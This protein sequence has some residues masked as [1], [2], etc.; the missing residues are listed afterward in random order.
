[1]VR[2]A[3]N[4]LDGV[5]ILRDC[6][7]ADNKELGALLRKARDAYSDLEPYPSTRPALVI[8]APSRCHETWLLADQDATRA[9]LGSE[10]VHR[11]SGNPED[12]P[13]CDNLK[14]HLENNARRLHESLTEVRR[15]LSFRARPTELAKRCQY[16]YPPFV[17]DV[18]QELRD[19]FPHLEVADETQPK[20]KP[21]R[22]RKNP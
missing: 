19:L 14:K 5:V 18:Q 22:L 13:H 16:C 9:I 8:A 15:R 10:G 2:A 17:Q 11:F 7:R 21:R 3:A 4:E 1:M 12:R 20:E 6:E